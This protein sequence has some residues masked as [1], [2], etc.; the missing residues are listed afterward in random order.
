MCCNI[1]AVGIAKE[2]LAIWQET[3]SEEGFFLVALTWRDLLEGGVIDQKKGFA[4]CVLHQGLI[5][6]WSGVS[7]ILCF[8]HFVAHGKQ[9]EKS[10]DEDYLA[11]A[12]QAWWLDL[13]QDFDQVVNPL[14][15][16]ML[17]P[18]F[19]SFPQVYHQ[20]RQ[21]GLR[22]P[23]WEFSTSKDHKATYDTV[24]TG[25]CTGQEDFRLGRNNGAM[26]IAYNKGTAMLCLLVRDRVFLK[27]LSTG[28]LIPADAMPKTVHHKL[29][30]LRIEL[31]LL[32]QECF[33]KVGGDGLWVLYHV[34]AQPRWQ[35]WERPVF[36]EVWRL[37]KK[38]TSAVRAYNIPRELR[39]KI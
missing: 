17:C 10:E 9:K 1:M 6:D 34:T 18:E 31:R 7:G 3:A 24:I 11:L 37:F 27:N 28:S 14:H 19:L 2:D 29:T 13:L 21:H 32:V 33:F 35:H 4:R 5:I 26:H 38:K 23:L 22:V 36:M 25:S 12:W 8:D 15:H 39:P 16:H 20:A 30:A